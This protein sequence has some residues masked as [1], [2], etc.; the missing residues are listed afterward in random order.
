[1]SVGFDQ[2]AKATE[3]VLKHGPKG[4][5]VLADEGRS[6][7]GRI[8]PRTP[9]GR[10]A[11]KGTPGRAVMTPQGPRASS[12]YSSSRGLGTLRKAAGRE[13]VAVPKAAFQ[14]LQREMSKIGRV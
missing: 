10:K 6:G 5:W 9:G 3:V 8:Y 12:S 4:L 7:S 1:L 13:R 2:G 11:R 14:A